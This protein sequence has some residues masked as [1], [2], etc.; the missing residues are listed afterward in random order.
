MTRRL[1]AGKPFT[2]VL[3]VHQKARGTGRSTMCCG[4]SQTACSVTLGSIP[5]HRQEMSLRSPRLHLFQH[6]SFST[7]SHIRWDPAPSCCPCSQELALLMSWYLPHRWS[8]LAFV[9]YLKVV[10]LLWL[11]ICN[12]TLSPFGIFLSSKKSAYINQSTN[13]FVHIHMVSNIIAFLYITRTELHQ[14]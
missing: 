2:W 5:T 1:Q 13:R 4:S 3:P 8:G 11:G 6:A 14:S 10:C 7:P 12:V 9:Y